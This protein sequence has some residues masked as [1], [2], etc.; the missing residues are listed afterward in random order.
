[1]TVWLV[2]VGPGEAELMTVKA[3]RLLEAADAV[4]HDRLI[5][6]DILRSVA[7]S[8]ER[9][10]VGKT[11]GGPGANQAEINGLL[12]SLASRFDTVVRV[13]GGDPYIFGRGIEEARACRA[14]GV[15]VEVVPGI[16]SALAGPLAAGISVTER[17]V[18]SGV[19]IV[20]AQQG[21]D[22]EPLDWKAL[23]D[24]GLTLVVLMGA[25]SAGRVRDTLIE[26]GMSPETPTAIAANVARPEQHCWRGTLRRLGRL[27]VTAPAVIVIGPVASG[28][29]KDLA[30]HKGTGRQ[31]SQVTPG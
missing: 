23:V 29:P 21:N 14:A 27:P 10:D 11:P 31:N 22:S 17:G 5:G 12:I 15:A 26:S 30:D 20:S 6:D 3:I 28:L 18:S 13:K 16:T 1:M 9:Y 2:G 7:P 25:R 4:V 24:T 19:C 8:A